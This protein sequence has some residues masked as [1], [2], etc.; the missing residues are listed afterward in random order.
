MKLSEYLPAPLIKYIYDF[1]DFWQHY[2]EVE[3]T[4][5]DYDRNHPVCLEGE[6]SAPPEDVG[7]SSGH[8]KFL[9]IIAD[10]THPEH[11]ETARWGWWQGYCEFDIERINKM[12]RFI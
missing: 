11:Q 10:K 5:H 9:E 8:E 2:I 7:G 6:G 3:R 12:L 1:G 4:L